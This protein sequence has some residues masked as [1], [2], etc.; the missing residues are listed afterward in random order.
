VNDIFRILDKSQNFVIINDSDLSFV[1]RQACARVSTKNNP[2]TLLAPRTGWE[3]I[4]IG[5]SKW[6]NGK[7]VATNR[8][9]LLALTGLV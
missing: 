2:I 7:H 9:R 3:F 1:N 6:A 4:L 8:S 5:V